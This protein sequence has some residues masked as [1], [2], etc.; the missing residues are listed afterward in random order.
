[1]TTL[2]AMPGA[3]LTNWWS[4]SERVRL[5]HASMPL[6]M[7]AVLRPHEG[8]MRL[9]RHAGACVRQRAQPGAGAACV[10]LLQQ[11]HQCLC[12]LPGDQQSR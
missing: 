5:A 6:I 10:Q 12:L 2:T 3:A 9:C 4:S 11:R 8:H 7:M 1:M